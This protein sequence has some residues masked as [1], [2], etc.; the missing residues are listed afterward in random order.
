MSAE[1]PNT[2]RF[3]RDLTENARRIYGYIFALVPNWADADEIFQE[4]SATLWTKYADYK[5]DTDFR[6]W[7]FRFA[8]FKVLQFRKAEGKNLLRLS[9]EFI[10]AVDRDAL[11]GD[12]LW[13]QRHRLLA[14]CYAQ[15][16]PQDRELLDLRYEPGATTKSVAEQVGRSTDAVYKALNRVHEQLLECIE[17][18]LEDLP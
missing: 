3:V 14:D 6:A 13:R 10:E 9:D 17:S 5:P 7:A 2:E 1:S 8:Y 18:K 12:D 4:T 11:A 16:R 15:L